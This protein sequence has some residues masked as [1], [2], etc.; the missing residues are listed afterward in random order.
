[1]KRIRR[2]LGGHASPARKRG[3]DSNDSNPVRK[4]TR[5]TS[6]GGPMKKSARRISDWSTARNDG[7]GSKSRS[8]HPPPQQLVGSK[9]PATQFED[10]DDVGD[11][12]DLDEEAIMKNGSAVGDEAPWLEYKKKTPTGDLKSLLLAAQK[13]LTG[14][15]IDATVKKV[16]HGDLVERL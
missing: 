4:S 2:D 16:I 6:D 13:R 8:V 9:T 11:W 1:M 14:W 10:D 7:S 12:V 5:R 15:D 3:Q